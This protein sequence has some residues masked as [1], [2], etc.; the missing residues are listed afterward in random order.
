MK[1]KKVRLQ[2]YR[3]YYGVNEID[4][5]TNSEENIILIGGKNGYGKTNLL[6]AFVWCLYGDR[7]SKTDSLFRKQIHKDGNYPKFLKNT[8]NWDAKKEGQVEYSVEI[9]F[10]DLNLPDSF[11]QEAS[12]CR[13]KR[14]VNTETLEEDL[15]VSIPNHNNGLFKEEEDKINFI[16][17]YLIPLDATKFVFFDAE[18]IAQMAELSTREEGELM[19][20]ALG[21]ILGLD[22]YEN[23]VEDLRLYSDNLKKEGATGNI[24]DQIIDAESTIKLKSAN[25]EK[26][27]K[28]IAELEETITD[29]ENKI[30]QYNEFI[31]DRVGTKDSIEAVNKLHER[32]SKLEAEIN[33]AEER[34]GEIAEI[35]PF[36][37]VSNLIEETVAHLNKQESIEL[38]NK[39]E[40][41]IENKAERFV[42]KLF[43]KPEFPPSE[44][45]SF[46]AKSFYAEKAKKVVKS[47]FANDN[48]EEASLKF[49]HDLTNSDQQL[50]EDTYNLIQGN[51]DKSF[52]VHTKD[53]IALNNELNE[54]NSK[55]RQ[56]ESEA[57]DDEVITY[58]DR[59]LRAS[60]Q[61][62]KHNKEIGVAE[63]EIK[64]ME[65]DIK[66]LKKN[67]KILLKKSAL[68]KKRQKEIDIIEAYIDLLNDFI[69]QEKK[70]KSERLSNN[71]LDE[72]RVLMHKLANRDT[73][74]I[75][76]V[77]VNPLPDNEGLKIELFDSEGKKFRKESL[78]EGE[79][80]LYI[81]SLI[82]ALLNEAIQNFP[83][84]IDTP[85]GRLDEEHIR[86]ILEYF[87]PNLA[88]QV[89]LM[90]TS[91]EIPPARKKIIED[92]I[93]ASYLLMNKNNQTS[94]KQGYFG[95][96]EN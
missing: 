22:I 29:L 34:F 35:I 67:K 46:S 47:V 19:N 83:I 88:D 58:R 38:K 92:Q 91:S 41:S 2:N 69:V 74:L 43:N 73:D 45:M 75:S 44:D 33:D 89:I 65:D 72:L 87:Y 63:N 56:F 6:L 10:Q 15:L 90:T 60:N 39:E 80:Q 31:N 50:I 70:E 36:G 78:S 95:N 79:K 64:K 81:S 25:I 21:N 61:I 94:F 14:S 28:R 62:E 1:I 68:S 86:N 37:L 57:A 84:V 20:D 17:D 3:Q 5:T 85:L 71:I 7:I 77:S 27:E 66:Q 54:V 49:Y 13:I 40:N 23:L 11:N 93:A 16:N 18:K 9:E 32:K 4:L 12:S 76:D 8:L 59:K 82:K 53:L 24:R 52:K 96:Y 26:H 55:I 48:E 51:I 30:D 42:E